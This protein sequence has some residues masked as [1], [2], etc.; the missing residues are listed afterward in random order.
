MKVKYLQLTIFFISFIY[1]QFS[2]EQNFGLQIG[3]ANI[4]TN[5]GFVGLE[6]RITNKTC[7]NIGVGSYATSRNNQIKILPEAHINLRPFNG[8]KILLDLI[9]TEVYLTNKF[10]N[11]SIGINLLNLIKIKN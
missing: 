2:V 4:G 10:I 5:Y 7:L 1:S 8:N 9:M 6:D 3:Y 11:P